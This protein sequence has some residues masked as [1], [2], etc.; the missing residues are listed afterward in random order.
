MTD[1]VPDRPGPSAE[2]ADALAHLAELLDRAMSELDADVVR[3]HIEACDPCTEAADVEEHV[4]ALIRRACREKAPEQL[5]VRI[6]SH[7]I[8]RS[9]AT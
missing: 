2:C 7:V 6:V 9:L 8:V 1:R 4:R 5:R 3:A